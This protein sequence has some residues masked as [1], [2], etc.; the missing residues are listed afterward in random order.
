MAMSQHLLWWTVPSMVQ[1]QGH[2]VK[3]FCFFYVQSVFKDGLVRDR[4]IEDRLDSTESQQATGR[5]NVGSESLDRSS[6]WT[7]GPIKRL[8][9]STLAADQDSAS[10]RSRWGNLH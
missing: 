1:R 3:L 2:G 9:T 8:T 5:Y 10:G 7:P 4:L 6:E